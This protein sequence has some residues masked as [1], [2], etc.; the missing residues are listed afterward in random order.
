MASRHMKHSCTH[1][2]SNADHA[3]SSS[4]TTANHHSLCL[5]LPSKPSLQPSPHHCILFSLFFLGFSL[6]YEMFCRKIIQHRSPVPQCCS[7]ESIAQPSQPK[8]SRE[9]RFI[10]DHTIN[11]LP[12]PQPMRKP[13]GI[14]GVSKNGIYNDSILHMA[15]CQEYLFEYV[16]YDFIYQKAKMP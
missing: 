3:R 7:F 8:P 13:I 2:F 4:R 16:I 6:C 14:G 1:A 15:F 9:F 12:Q 11:F 5:S 10:P